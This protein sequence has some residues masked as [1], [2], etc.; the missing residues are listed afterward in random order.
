MQTHSLHPSFTTGA[1]VLASGPGAWRLSIPAG[2]KGAYRLAQV[3]D[4]FG[5]TRRAFHWRAPFALELRARVSTAD[6]PGTWGFGLWNDPFSAGLGVGGTSARLPA[7][8]NAAWFFYASPPNHL[9]FHDGHPAQGFLAA[10]FSAPR[11]PSALTIFGLPGVP[12]LALPASARLV[13]GLLA[14]MLR[15]DAA[16][17]DLDVTAWHAYRMEWLEKSCRF[18]VDG[19]MVFET[20]VSPRGPLGLVI[21]VDNQYAAFPP[22]GRL[23]SGTLAGPAAWM[24]V[25]IDI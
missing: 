25:E 7:L 19:R 1:E 22:D 11:V 14:R 18:H 10:T 6:L 17:L 21:W 23:R 24:E 16:Q 9:A 5:L 13:R 12:L 20:N 8:P 15:E 4:T 3:D 2:E